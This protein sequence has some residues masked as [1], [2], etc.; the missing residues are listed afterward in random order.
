MNA[1]FAR[2]YARDGLLAGITIAQNAFFTGIQSSFLSG[3]LEGKLRPY[4]R[5]IVPG[6]QGHFLFAPCIHHSWHDF[7]PVLSSCLLTNEFSN[8]WS[9]CIVRPSCY[10]Q[11]FLWAA[12]AR[13]S[14]L[15]LG[16]SCMKSG[17]RLLCVAALRRTFPFAFCRYFLITHFCC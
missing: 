1:S 8:P 10:R 17:I 15:R 11:Y 5:G 6:L 16:F 9:A 7:E 3:D 2:Q 4:Q 12:L 14:R 13:Y